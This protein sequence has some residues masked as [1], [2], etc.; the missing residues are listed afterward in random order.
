MN[1]QVRD[2]Q[3]ELW[4]LIE[5]VEHG[6]VGTPGN[7]GIYGGNNGTLVVAL[8]T[9]TYPGFPVE[10]RWRT[11]YI[12]EQVTWP[13]NGGSFFGAWYIGVDDGAAGL[14]TS[15]LLA[16]GDAPE[17]GGGVYIYRFTPSAGSHT[18]RIS[19]W[20]GNGEGSDSAAA[21]SGSLSLWE[22]GG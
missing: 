8:S 10:L 3:K 17:W 11:Q 6:P 15:Y 9:R 4:R 22:R 12:L 7:A 18:Y 14:T 2:N 21:M 19:I 13:G 16:Q 5:T 20:S 1:A